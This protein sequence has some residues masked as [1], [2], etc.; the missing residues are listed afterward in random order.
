MR[1]D[2]GG[3]DRGHVELGDV[4]PH[5][6]EPPPRVALRQKAFGAFGAL[7]ALGAFGFC[8]GPFVGVGG[9]EV[10][11]RGLGAPEVPVD[12]LLNNR[13]EKDDKRGRIKR[14]FEKELFSIEHLCPCGWKK[15]ACVEGSMEE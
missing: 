4:R 10:A 2:P 9:E 15:C 1:Q 11:H 3:V 14:K 6:E 12:E 8:G 7:G 13:H 5:D